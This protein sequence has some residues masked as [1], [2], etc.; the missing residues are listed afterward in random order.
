MVEKGKERIMTYFCYCV[1]KTKLNKYTLRSCVESG[2]L[3]GR[4][5]EGIGIWKRRQKTGKI[6]SWWSYM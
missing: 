2:K 1:F 3:K 5:Q 6:P 4:M